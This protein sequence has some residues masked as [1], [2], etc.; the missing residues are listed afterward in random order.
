MY[1]HTQHA[2]DVLDSLLNDRNDQSF[3]ELSDQVCSIH[4]EFK[5]QLE[6]RST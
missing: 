6:L 4:I 2:A 5:T 1:L 3:Q